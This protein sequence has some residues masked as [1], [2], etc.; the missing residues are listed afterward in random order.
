[1]AIFVHE[2]LFLERCTTY[3]SIALPPLLAGASQVSLTLLLPGLATG[4]RGA[5]G[6]VAA[7]RLIAASGCL[8]VVTVAVCGVVDVLDIG[9]VVDVGATWATTGSDE[10]WGS[11]VVGA[12]SA[13]AGSG[14]G[15][16]RVDGAVVS[17]GSGAVGTTSPST[18]SVLEL[19]GVSS[20]GTSVLTGSSGAPL[21]ARTLAAP[22]AIATDATTTATMPPRRMRLFISCLL[23][24]RTVGPDQGGPCRHREIR[25]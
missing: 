4:E 17:V 20:A 9:V 16:G 12:A 11:V 18:A 23:L 19:G 24:D 6:A 2:V 7:S 25:A 5:V 14:E 10:A 3:L 15:G 22:A 1:V 8:V 13:L 21:S